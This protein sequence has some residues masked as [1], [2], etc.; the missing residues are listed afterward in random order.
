MCFPL[1]IR[2]ILCID[3]WIY[4]ILCMWN[5][6]SSCFVWLLFSFLF[7]SIKISVQPSLMTIQS[8]EKMLAIQTLK[9]VCLI[10]FFC[11]QPRK[12]ALDF[13]V[14]LQSLPFFSLLLVERRAS[15]K[16]SSIRKSVPRMFA[17]LLAKIASSSLHQQNVNSDRPPQFKCDICQ[18]KFHVEQSLKRHMR[19]LTGTKPFT[20]DICSRGFRGKRDMAK[21]K[22]SHAG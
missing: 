21:H 2:I 20:C 12:F 1:L 7:H 14:M 15:V 19:V 9:I 5:L 22:K 11:L 13:P 8:K 18:R 3:L 17:Q 4:Y 6:Q 16:Q 10:V